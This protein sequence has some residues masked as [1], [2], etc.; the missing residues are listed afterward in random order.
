MQTD[1]GVWK[2]Q[3]RLKAGAPVH[4]APARPPLIACPTLR[5]ARLCRSLGWA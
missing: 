4:Q 1:S 5:P 3:W 2:W